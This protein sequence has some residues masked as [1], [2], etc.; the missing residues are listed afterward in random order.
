MIFSLA[1]GYIGKLVL[2]SNNNALEEEIA[3]TSQTLIQLF[4]T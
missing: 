2:E 4:K 3:F 1:G